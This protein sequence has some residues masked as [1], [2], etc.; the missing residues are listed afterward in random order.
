M[1]I[2]QKR[3]IA[4]LVVL[5]LCF[6]GYKI[7]AHAIAEQRYYFYCELL[8]PGLT[9]QQV[10]VALAQLGSYTKRD[11]PILTH[12]SY[13]NYNNAFTQL[14]RLGSV[15]SILLWFD[16]NDLLLDASPSS[17]SSWRTVDCDEKP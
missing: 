6:I 12:L 4:A 10:G 11:D 14:V 15:G 9:H 2:T 16:D 1:S 8:R 5:V 7:I 13:V 17:G 3:I